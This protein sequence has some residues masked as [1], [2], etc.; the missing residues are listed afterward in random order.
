MKVLVMGLGAIGHTVV[1][2]VKADQIDV[3]VSKKIDITTI[4]STD[5]KYENKVDNVYTYNEMEVIDYDYLFVTLPYQYKINR[6]KEV[7]PRVT[8]RTT[9][10]FIPGN[11]GI[12]SYMPEE[13]YK[14]EIILF[15]RVIHISRT[16]EYGSLV[17]ITG[18][19]ENM[20][21][22][23]SKGVN[24]SEFEAL[25]PQVTNFMSDHHLIDISMVSSNAVIHN[26]RTYRAFKTEKLFG[27]E[28]YFYK[29]WT[30]EDSDLFIKLEKEVMAINQAIEVKEGFKIKYYSMFQHFGVDEENPSAS[31]LTKKIAN[32]KAFETITFFAA[33]ESEL[34]MNRYIVDDMVIALRFYRALAKAYKVQT[35]LMDYMYEFG[36]SLLNTIEK[37]LIEKYNFELNINHISE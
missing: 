37:D 13:I 1:A 22:A 34:A 5:G 36:T 10:V 2:T 12:L 14:H 30:D 28:F 4:A 7:L 35:P 18:T 17:R 25:F 16:E 11:Q 27:E 21:I 20:H 26:P 19:K 9:I 24:K 3:L 31:E 23:Y 15:E 33:N 6:V 32:N 8:E 29:T